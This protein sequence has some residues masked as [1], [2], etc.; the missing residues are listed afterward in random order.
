[1]EPASL[2]YTLCQC[3]YAGTLIIGKKQLRTFKYFID[4]INILMYQGIF[5]QI[6]IYDLNSWFL[7]SCRYYHDVMLYILF[8]ENSVTVLI[9]FYLRS[10]YTQLYV[11]WYNIKIKEKVS[12]HLR[13][14]L[15][16]EMWCFHLWHQQDLDWV[17]EMLF[18][19]IY[20]TDCFSTFSPTLKIPYQWL[21]IP[22]G[23]SFNKIIH[24]NIPSLKQFYLW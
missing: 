4:N 17:R 12:R 9:T 7:M 13:D 10:T 5:R 2:Y 11:T 3:S 16:V 23:C 6:D 1:M 14:M 18:R 20:K 15:E 19:F 22:L 24:Q 8:V 21:P